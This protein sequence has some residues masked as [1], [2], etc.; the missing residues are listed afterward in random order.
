MASMLCFPES[1]ICAGSLGAGDLER[2]Q[3]EQLQ[4][5]GT[6]MLQQPLASNTWGS[7]CSREA[8]LFLLYTDNLGAMVT[9]LL[10]VIFG[11]SIWRREGVP[12][13]RT[14]LCSPRE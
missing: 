1:V 7:L 3:W 6:E 10:F 13:I 11:T 9:S 12:W 4:V 8:A 14:R 5:Q 2:L